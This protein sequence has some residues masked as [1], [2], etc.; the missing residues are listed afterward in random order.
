ML[1]ITTKLDL[2]VN[3]LL[4][5]NVVGMSDHGPVF[6]VIDKVGTLDFED[7]SVDSPT[8]NGQVEH[9]GTSA[10]ISEAS[11]NA[12]L[13]NESQHKSLIAELEERRES[14]D[15]IIQELKRDV[16]STDTLQTNTGAGTLSAATK[17]GEISSPVAKPRKMRRY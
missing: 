7:D 4:L 6:G 16:R 9:A 14:L 2:Q 3:D 5:M 11:K 10:R 13:Q 15:I 1:D 17:L 8:K 12:G